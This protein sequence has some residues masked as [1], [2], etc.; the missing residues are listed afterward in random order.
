MGD[1]TQTQGLT[2]SPTGWAPTKQGF[3]DPWTGP[4]PRAIPEFGNPKDPLQH[5]KIVQN[6]E[7]PQDATTP[8]GVTLARQKFTP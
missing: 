5:S 4:K 3:A 8:S 6:H 7:T 1:F 2:K